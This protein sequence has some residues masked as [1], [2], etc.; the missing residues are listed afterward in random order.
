MNGWRGQRAG[1]AENL[2]SLGEEATLG[3]TG[4]VK[5]QEYETTDPRILNL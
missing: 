3:S 1:A 4:N 5:H 2:Q